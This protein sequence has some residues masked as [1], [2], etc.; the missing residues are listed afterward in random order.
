M[1]STPR[2]KETGQ[3]IFACPVHSSNFGLLA[4]FISEWVS[5]QGAALTHNKSYRKEGGCV[6]IS[7]TEGGKGDKTQHIRIR[8]G[9]TKPIFWGFKDREGQDVG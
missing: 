5:C 3:A 6:K 9:T 7:V 1:S 4:N 8:T 2:K